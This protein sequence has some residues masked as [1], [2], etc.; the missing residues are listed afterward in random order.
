M[1]R[2]ISALLLAAVLLNACDSSSKKSAPRPPADFEMLDPDLPSMDELDLG[3]VENPVMMQYFQWYTPNDG[4]HWQ[5]V[6]TNAEELADKGITALWL[7]PA[8]KGFHG[9][10]DVGYAVYD[11]YDLGEFP[12]N[13]TIR[14]KYGT[15]D[16]YL[17]AITAAQ[18]AGIRVY[19]DVVLN[20]KMGADRTESV[21]AV[22]VNPRNRLQD[23][24]GEI[25]IDA[26][27][28]FDFPGRGNTYSDFKWRWYH[29]DGV[30]FAANL[31]ESGTIYR[32]LDKAKSWDSNVSK[33]NGNYD[34]L[35]GADL[36]MSHP[37]VIQQLKSWGAWYVDFTGIDGFRLDAI[38]H[39]RGGF[40]NDWLAHVRQASGRPL[41]AVGEYWSSQRSE[42]MSYLRDHNSHDD[43]MFL[44][45]VPLHRNF[46]NASRANGSYDMSR[47][48]S[49]TLVETAPQRA[50]TLVENHDTQPLQALKAPVEDWFK[51]LAYALILLREQGYP[52]IFYA[53]YYGASYR[54]RGQD[55]NFHDIRL[56]SHQEI[57][58]L[59]LKARHGF[60]HGKQRDYFD[61]TDVVG[62]TRAGNYSF[63]N[64][65]A[66][67]LSDGAA[68][69]KWMK[70]GAEHEGR[71]FIDITG[72][73]EDCTY[74]NE[75]GWAKFRTQARQ[76]SVWV[77][78]DEEP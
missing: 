16:E 10:N 38:K 21:R 41:F 68:G 78:Q 60:S 59:L 54:D 77:G 52:S 64:G 57:I 15:K 22:R 70:L 37:E 36:D 5:R 28:A 43:V 73:H 67:I 29:F 1:I 27:T 13:G 50:V 24:G 35:M 49:G 25:M 51:P 17:A 40:F 7:P 71:C 3:P 33:E 12:Q 9:I 31:R 45:D 18:N 44:F 58:D 47:I 62:W 20:H 69:T 55:G 6:A 42:L 4:D 19:A 75:E 26:Y 48:F 74:I 72:L 76:V 63:P 61:H 65:L 23:I 66:V 34:Y 46:H 11:L 56:A 8:F 14:T 2:Q 32:F 30:N 39:I 53:D